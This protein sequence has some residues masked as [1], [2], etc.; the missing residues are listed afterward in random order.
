MNIL[1]VVAHPDDE[2]LGMGGTILK[3]TQ[4]K[5]DVFIQI[6]TE[7]VSARDANRVEEQKE[8]AKECARCLGAKGVIFGN[9]AD[10]RLDTVPLL[11]LA[12]AVSRMISNCKPEIVY[13]HFWGDVNQDHRQVFEAVMIATRPTPNKSVRKVLCFETP[14]ATEWRSLPDSCFCPNYFVDIS[15]QLEGKINAFK[16]YK[17][18]VNVFPH[19]RSIESVMHLARWRGSTVGFNA[20]EAFFLI[21][22]LK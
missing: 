6:L 22:E 19:P 13:T 15:Q 14:S 5:D 20:A 7:G 9:F 17:L 18:E 21:R 11:D 1:V 4:N 10:Q 2:V 8:F 16:T 12:D 3:H